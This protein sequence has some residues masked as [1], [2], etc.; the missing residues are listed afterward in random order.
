MPSYFNLVSNFTGSNNV[1]P[2]VVN[3]A[4]YVVVLPW[5]SSVCRATMTESSLPGMNLKLENP[6][7]GLNS[8]NFTTFTLRKFSSVDISTLQPIYSSRVSLYRSFEQRRGRK[9]HLRWMTDHIPDSCI[10]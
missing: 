9:N 7:V 5:I 3:D 1:S 4:M 10:M 2:S 8:P 6:I